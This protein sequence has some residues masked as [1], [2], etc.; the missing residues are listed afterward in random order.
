[1]PLQGRTQYEQQTQALAR[2][3]GTGQGQEAYI[4]WR[5]K[6]RIPD[7]VRV[8]SIPGER[9]HCDA[10]VV[11]LAKGGGRKGVTCV[12]GLGGPQQHSFRNSICQTHLALATQPLITSCPP[13]PASTNVHT[14]APATT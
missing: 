11:G 1:M 3:Y 4:Q 8:F 14:Q 5:I 6:H 9:D 10:W 12:G 2:I 7:H 13:P